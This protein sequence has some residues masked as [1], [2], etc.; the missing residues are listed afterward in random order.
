MPTNYSRD[1]SQGY[2]NKV[3]VPGGFIKISLDITDGGKFQFYAGS[4][5]GVVLEVESRSRIIAAADWA[6]REDRLGESR[7]KSRR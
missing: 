3:F 5:G 6:T 1:K 7:T 4:V 2:K